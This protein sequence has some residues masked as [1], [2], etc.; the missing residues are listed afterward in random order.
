MAAHVTIKAVESK[1]AK[2]GGKFQ[3][4]EYNQIRWA[5]IGDAVVEYIAQGDAA[6]CLSVRRCNDHHEWQSDY[7]EGSF[8]S[9]IRQA[10]R[11]VNG[12]NTGRY[13]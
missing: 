7:H 10:I 3:R 9:S 12:I 1:F 5:Q 6:S 4:S 8:C 13:E 2:L 11:F